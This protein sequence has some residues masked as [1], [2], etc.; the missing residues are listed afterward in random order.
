LFCWLRVVE[1]LASRDIVIELTRLEMLS[2]ILNVP[3]K[4]G[5]FEPLI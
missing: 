3:A 2:H 1:K 4:N 5:I